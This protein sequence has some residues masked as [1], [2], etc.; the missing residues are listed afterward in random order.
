LKRLIGL[1]RG[2]RTEPV[3]DGTQSQGEY[4]DINLKNYEMLLNDVPETDV[5]GTSN[6]LQIA[7]TGSISCRAPTVGVFGPMQ[8]RILAQPPSHPLSFFATEFPD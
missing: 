5:F 7:I 6:F 1:S 4:R 3:I 2:G 8:Q